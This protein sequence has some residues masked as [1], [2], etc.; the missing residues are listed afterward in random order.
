MKIKKITRRWTT[1]SGERKERVYEY[2]VREFTAKNIKRKYDSVIFTKKDGKY[3]ENKRA[4]NSL[5]KSIKDEELRQRIKDVINAVKSGDFKPEQVEMHNVFNPKTGK[6]EE[7]PKQVSADFVTES[8]LYSRAI[9]KSRPEAG[10]EKFFANLGYTPEEIANYLGYEYI[11]GYNEQDRDS[12]ASLLLN[13]N[14]WTAD[15]LTFNYRGRDYVFEYSFKY[16]LNSAF[17]LLN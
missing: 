14:N 7:V 9:E 5:L 6:W 17:K 2:R 12:L 16:T 8:A 4:V 3:V 1:K 11:E 13:Q 15:T 10:Q